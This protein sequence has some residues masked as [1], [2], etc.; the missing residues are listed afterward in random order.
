MPAHDTPI[1]KNL[2]RPAAA[3]MRRT[4]DPPRTD[5]PERPAAPLDSAA[6]GRGAAVLDS[7]VS[8]RGAAVF[9]SAAG[10][11]A[12]HF[13][14]DDCPIRNSFIRPPDDNKRAEN[15]RPCR[16]CCRRPRKTNAPAGDVPAGAVSQMFSVFINNPDSGTRPDCRLPP[17]S[18]PAQD[19]HSGCPC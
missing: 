16:P 12:A 5:A 4:N 17:E 3:L 1:S 19:A 7:A 14:S 13:D 10:R 15:R 9:D 2:T 8:G 6:F 18:T 11:G